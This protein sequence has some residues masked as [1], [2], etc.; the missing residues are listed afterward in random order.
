MSKAK[1]MAATRMMSQLVKVSGRGAGTAAGSDTEDSPGQ[2]GGPVGLVSLYGNPWRRSLR[3]DDLQQLDG[4]PAVAVDVGEPAVRR[5]RPV[6]GEPARQV[7]P[8]N[9]P[10]KRRRLDPPQDVVLDQDSPQR[11][12][13]GDHLGPDGGAAVAEVEAHDAV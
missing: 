5:P 9:H 4:R 7:R 1:P 10:Q 2:T 11:R 8:R 13:P 6:E 3:R 12:L